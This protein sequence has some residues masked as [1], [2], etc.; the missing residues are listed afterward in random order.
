[1]IFLIATQLFSRKKAIWFSIRSSRGC[2]VF[3]LGMRRKWRGKFWP[4]FSIPRAVFSLLV[5]I[6]SVQDIDGIT[7][8]MNALNEVS[9]IFEKIHHSVIV[10]N[11]Q[12]HNLRQGDKGTREKQRK[13]SRFL[14]VGWIYWLSANPDAFGGCREH[15]F[16]FHREKG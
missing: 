6:K 3:F 11:S 4:N 5:F 2:G 16:A 1:M 9:V 10:S 7:A 12:V 13:Q 15:S 14:L 8:I